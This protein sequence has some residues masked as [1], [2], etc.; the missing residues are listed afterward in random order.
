[1]ENVSKKIAEYLLQI[2]AI[3]LQPSNPFTWASGWKS[4]IY[5]DNRKTLSFP[6]VRTFICDSFI[7]AVKSYYPDVEV[8]AGVA[9]GA[10]AHG[11][12]VA[13]KMGL[14]F[15]YVRSEAK[16]HGLGN[17]IEGYFEKGQKVV[18]IEDLVST[19]GTSLGAVRALREAGCEVLG[20][21]AIFTYGFQKAAEGFL[22]EN[23]E[24]HTLS[25][26]NTLIDC[27]L[28]TGYIGQA[29]VETLREW[30]KDPSKW[31]V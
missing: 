14:P 5:C 9:T 16:S 29:D 28:E 21:I 26:Y 24:L 25:D 31:G 8:I 1:M 19:G 23:C 12:L 22:S 11:A 10:I 17:Q 27:A 20:M 7:Q 3:K 4:P 30:R 18:V 15:I 13:Q 2:K 6:E